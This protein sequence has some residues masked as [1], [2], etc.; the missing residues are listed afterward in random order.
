MQDQVYYNCFMVYV[1]DLYL[2]TQVDI[3]GLPLWDA[4]MGHWK[5]SDLA[6]R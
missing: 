1:A 3:D 2:A 6:E 5:F 4:Q